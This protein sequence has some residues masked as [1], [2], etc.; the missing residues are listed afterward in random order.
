MFK[1]LEAEITR[2][3]ILKRDIAEFL[4]INTVTLT[5]KLTGKTRFKLSEAVKIRNKYFP[6]LELEYLFK[7]EFDD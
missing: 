7:E 2:T 6:G 3:G 5:F 1:N 4:G